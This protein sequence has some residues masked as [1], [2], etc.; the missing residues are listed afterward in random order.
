M[1]ESAARLAAGGRFSSVGAAVRGAGL[2]LAAARAGESLC[3]LVGAALATAAAAQLSGADASARGPSWA[4]AAL[5]GACAGASWWLEHRRERRRVAQAL[6]RKLAQRGALATAHE[7]ELVRAAPLAP[8]EALLRERVL[9]SLARRAT[10]GALV[11][12]PWTALLAPA[13]GALTLALALEAGVVGGGER[14]RVAALASGLSAALGAAE[15]TPRGDPATRDELAALERAL[16]AADA[17]AAR[18]ELERLDRTLAERERAAAREARPALAS[19]RAWLDALR[20]ALERPAA[21]AADGMA[22][23]ELTA[24]APDGTIWRSP[25]GRAP[26]GTRSAMIPTAPSDPDVPPPAERPAAEAP[27][28]GAARWWPVEADALVARW[29]ELSRQDASR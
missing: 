17:G 27:A 28:A 5:A 25:A 8:L 10:L 21:G 29:L 9:A 13:L 26:D 3:V 7:L 12:P 23:A 11:P 6:D 22:G 16:A 20:G 15:E 4:V 19:A 24:A 18:A 1:S 2:A 14:E